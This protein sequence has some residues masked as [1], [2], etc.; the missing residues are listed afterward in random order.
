VGKIHNIRGEELKSEVYYPSCFGDKGQ[1][2]K[3]TQPKL[4][5][6]SR[7][8]FRQGDEHSQRMK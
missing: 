1:T 4:H 7:T 2:N 5:S 3:Q 6:M 8:F